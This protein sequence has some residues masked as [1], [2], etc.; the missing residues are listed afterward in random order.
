MF[1]EKAQRFTLISACH[2]SKNG[3]K[4][5]LAKNKYKSL[6]LKE[7]V[8]KGILQILKAFMTDQKLNWW[9][10][11]FSLKSKT[12]LIFIEKDFLVPKKQ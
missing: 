10:D 6:T 5:D 4:F 8:S 9:R 1:A 3:K 11:D 2:Q 7:S 12:L